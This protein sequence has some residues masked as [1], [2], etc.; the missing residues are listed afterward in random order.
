MNKKGFTLIE[1]LAAMTILAIITAALATIF[2]QGRNTWQ[3]A[4]A[5][6]QQY[7]A[8]RSVLQM[9]ARELKGAIIRPKVG[10]ST[11]GGWGERFDFV[12]VKGK[13][14]DSDG[15][16]LPG[17]RDSTSGPYRE[18]PYSDQVYFVAPVENSSDYEECLIGYWVKDTD[19]NTA[20]DASTGKLIN[21]KDDMLM[22]YYVT[23]GDEADP[24]PDW[25]DFNFATPQ[26]GSM[27]ENSFELG[28]NIRWLRMLYWGPNTEEWEDT[29]SNSKNDALR[30]WD[31]LPNSL[32]SSTPGTSDDDN[33]LPRAVKITIW[34]QDELQREK[35]RT[36]STIVYLS[37]YAEP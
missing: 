4:D 12:G 30:K 25:R 29:D 36:F 17:W 24:D 20:Y 32:G 33:R 7:L 31:T 8:A 18:Q 10:P 14:D 35:T 23:A 11:G 9:M 16:V 19:S 3:K 26:G 5:R 22:K 34:V 6:T 15:A 37:N 21:T 13:D 2:T 27:A 1:I 28:I